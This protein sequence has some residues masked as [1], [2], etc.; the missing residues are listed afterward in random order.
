MNI[1]LDENMPLRLARALGDCG[2]QVDTT[3]EEGLKG[4]ADE[5]VWKAAQDAGR[6]LITQDL[7]F[8]DT[9]RFAPGTHH[10]ILLVRLTDPGRNALVQRVQ[11]LFLSEDVAGWEE[12]FIVLTDHKLRI[13]RP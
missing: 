5:R 4:Q 6:F 13:L 1:K 9:R 3:V 12:C 11:Q 2:H 8:S 10:G 7:D